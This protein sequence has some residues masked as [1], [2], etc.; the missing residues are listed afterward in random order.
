MSVA[1][2]AE[3]EGVCTR[4]IGASKTWGAYDANGQRWN[5]TFVQTTIKFA[6]RE[7][8]SYI[9]KTPGH[10]A[11]VS[12]FV[13]SAPLAHK[14]LL[15]Q[16]LAGYADVRVDNEHAEVMSATSEIE[17]LRSHE[18]VST[19]ELLNPYYVIWGRRIYHTGTLAIVG[20]FPNT[21]PSGNTLLCPSEYS[22][23]IALGA[24]RLQALADFGEGQ[25]S[26]DLAQEYRSRIDLIKDDANLGIVREVPAYVMKG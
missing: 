26:S 25:I 9:A 13:D 15:P 2:M 1:T 7:L 17:R 24:L 8:A 5:T 3:I 21:T 10:P 14:E 11:N 20:Y 23:A 18:T 16:S 12:L 4:I 22:Y 6:D 19:D